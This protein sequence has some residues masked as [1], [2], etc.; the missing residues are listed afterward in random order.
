MVIK[1]LKPH[2]SASGSVPNGVCGVRK[3]MFP[4]GQSTE[5]GTSISQLSTTVLMVSGIGEI[6]TSVGL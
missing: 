1:A 5:Y 2:F 3:E 6:L 4:S